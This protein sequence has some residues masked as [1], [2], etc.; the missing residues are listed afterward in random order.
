MISNKVHRKRAAATLALSICLITSSTACGSDEKKVVADGVLKPGNYTAAPPP[1]SSLGAVGTTK[2]SLGTVASDAEGFTLYIF[3]RDKKGS[4]P[5][6]V[7]ECAKTWEP[8]LAPTGMPIAFPGVDAQ[9]LTVVSRTDGKRQI[10]LDGSP[11]YRYKEDKKPGDVTG[12][13]L[14]NEWHAASATGVAL[15]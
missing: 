10:A 12:H 14:S 7:G 6:C 11:L 9:K 13:R 3:K 5:K 8:V 15:K 1:A 2:T 4:A